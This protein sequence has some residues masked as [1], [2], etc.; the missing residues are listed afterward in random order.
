[1]ELK[2][3]QIIPGMEL[4]IQELSLGS[5]AEIRIPSD[6]AYGKNGIPRI[7]PPESELI[8][9]I[10]ILEVDGLPCDED[11]LGKLARPVDPLGLGPGDFCHPWWL[12]RVQPL[13]PPAYYLNF[14]AQTAKGRKPVLLENARSVAR[15]KS[16]ELT[17][18]DVGTADEPFI[19]TDVQRGWQ[20]NGLWD[21]K[22]F[23]DHLGDKRQ[24]LKWL[25]PVF[26]RQECLWEAPVYETSVR[27][28]IKY[29]RDLEQK[30]PNCD[31]ENAAQCPR[32]YLN[33]WPAFAQ[34]PWL[35][36]FVLPDGGRE[37]ASS[38]QG[39]IED[40]NFL[41]IR[42][43]EALRESLLEGLTARGSYQPPDKA[44]QT[45]KLEDEDWDLTKIFMSPKGAITRLHYDNGGAHA[46]SLRLTAGLVGH[47]D[48]CR[49]GFPRSKDEKQRMEQQAA[50]VRS[51][52]VGDVSTVMGSLH[53]VDAQ[54]TSLGQT[55][56]H[57]ASASGA[58]PLVVALL[59][60]GADCNRCD[61]TGASAVAL[62]AAAGHAHVLEKLLECNSIKVPTYD[63]AGLTPVHKAVGFGQPD[64]LRSLL[65]HGVDPNVPTGEVTLPADSGAAPSRHETALHIA[66]R[67]LTRAIN[68]PDGAGS[69]ERQ[70]LQQR[71]LMRMLVSYRANAL[72]KDVNGDT[73][74]HFS[75]RTGDL[76]GFCLLLDSDGEHL[77]PFEGDEGLLNGSWLDPLDPDVFEKWPDAKKATPYLA[78]VEAGE[79]I[80]APKG[81]W[82]YAV[83]LDSSVTIM[84]NFYST[85]NQWDL[86]RRKD[87]G[88]AGAIAT[89][90]L[91]SIQSASE[92]VVLRKQPKLKNQPDSVIQEIAQKTVLKLRVAPKH[93][94]A[95]WFHT[96]LAWLAAGQAALID[97][98]NVVCSVPESY[99]RES[100]KKLIQLNCDK[101]SKSV[102]DFTSLGSGETDLDRGLVMLL[103][104]DYSLD[105]LQLGTLWAKQTGET[106]RL[107]RN[108]ERTERELWTLPA[109]E[110]LAQT[111]DAATLAVNAWGSVMLQGRKC[112]TLPRAPYCIDTSWS[113]STV[114]L[115]VPMACLAILFTISVVSSWILPQPSKD[116]E[117]MTEREEVFQSRPGSRTPRVSCRSALKKELE[118]AWLERHCLR[119]L[120]GAPD[121][122]NS[123]S[124]LFGA[125]KETLDFQA[126]SV[127]NQFE[128]FLSL[129]RSSCAMV[130]D[131]SVG[132]GASVNEAILLQEAAGDLYFEML[133]GFI[134]WRDN[135]RNYEA[136]TMLSLSEDEPHCC[137]LE[138]V[139]LQRP[140]PL[141]GAKWEPLQKEGLDPS[142]ATVLSRQL[143]EM[144][145]YL[146][147]WGEAG[148]VRF[149]PEAI[150][151]ITELALAANPSDFEEIYGVAIPEPSLPGAPFRSNFF[152]SKIIRPI[153]NVVF[154]EWYQYVD[155]DQNNQKDKKKLKPGLENF[156]PPDVSWKDWNEFFCD[157]SRMVEGLLLQD[158]TRLFD[159]PHERR[160]L[161][162]PRVDWQVT[163]E[164]AETKTHREIH[165]LWG[166]FATTHRIVLLHLILFFSGVCAVAG[167]AEPLDGQQPLLG[168]S[169]GVRFAAVAL[170]VPVHALLWAC[171]R[172]QVT[173]RVLRLQAP[174]AC[175]GRSLWKALWWMLPVLT[176]A[177]IRDSAL[178]ED[179]QFGL[180]L[181][182]LLVLHFALSGTGLAYLLFVPS[183][184]CIRSCGSNSD[185]MWE[186][187][188]VPLTARLVRYLFWIVL[189]SVKFI[190]GLIIFRAM[191][192]ATVELQ[193]ALPGRESVSE[194]SRIYYSTE[195]GSDFLLWFVLWFTTL[196]LFISDT[197]L[198]FTLLCSILGVSTVLVQRGCRCFTWALEDSVAKLPERFSRK[199]L[200][201]SF[202]GSESRV[203]EQVAHFSPYFPAIWDRILEYMRYEDKIDN[204]LMGDLSF[205]S[206]ESGHQVYWKQLRQPLAKRRTRE[207][208]SPVSPP[209]TT[210]AFTEDTPGEKIKVPDIFREKTAFEVGFKTYCCMHDAHWPNNAD[211]QW[212]LL[213]LSRG[214]GLPMPRPFRAPYFPGLTVCIPH[215]GESILM[216][217]KELFQGRE[218]NV[219]LMDW[220]AA[221]Y[222][223]EFLTF[224]NRMQ[225]DKG[226]TAELDLVHPKQKRRYYS[227]LIDGACE[228]L[229]TGLKKA[230]FRVE[231]P[232]YPI[233][234][235]GKGDNQ[236]HAIPFMRGEFRSKKRG[237]SLSKRIV[238][239]PE[240]ITSDIGSI[241]DF[242]ASAEVAFGT[243]LQRTYAVLGARMHYGHPDIM[244]KLFMMQQG[245]VSKATKTV[246]LSEDIFAGMDFTLR[247]NGRTIKHSEY[248]H[249]AKGRD[250]GFNTVL[251]FFSKLSSG[252][253]EQVL[254]RQAFR[255]GQVLHLPEALTFYYAHVGY[256]FTQLFVSWSMPLLV[257]VWLLVLLADEVRDGIFEA[258]LNL[259]QVQ[260][261]S[262]EVMA[263]TVGVWFSWL[264][265]LFLIATS[266]PLLAEMWMERNLKVACERFFKQMLTLSPLMF[267]FQAKIIGH[268]VINEIRYGGATYVSTGRGLPTDRR[269]FIGE[270]VPGKF[271]LKRLGGLYL[272]YAS[273]AYYD[274]VTLLAGVILIYLAGGV[275]G[276]GVY[277]SDVWWVFICLFLTVASWLWAPFIF[278]P[279]QFV[280]KHFCEDFRCLVAFFLEDSGR[281]W[282]EWYDRTQLKPRSGGLHRSM[283]AWFVVAVFFLAAWY[284]MINM[285][286]D[287]LM[288][289]YS[290]ALSSNMLHIAALLPP[291]GA[292]FTYCLLAVFFESLVGCS[293][294]LRRRMKAPG[295]TMRL[296]T[297]AT[298]ALGGRSA[299]VSQAPVAISQA[300]Q[301]PGLPGSREMTTATEEEAGRRG[302][303]TAHGHGGCRFAT[304]TRT[305]CVEKER[306]ERN[307]SVAGFI[308]KWGLLMICIFF[309]E[310]ML[311][312]NEECTTRDRTIFV[313]AAVHISFSSTE[314][315]GIWP[316]QRLSWMYSAKGIGLRR[317]SNGG[318]TDRASTRILRLLRLFRVVR[319]GKLTR[320]AVFLRDTCETQ[321]ASIQFSL[322]IIMTGMM[323]LE[324]VLACGWFGVGYY[325]SANGRSWLQENNLKEETFYKQY[326]ASLR[327]SFSQLGIGGTNI[328]AT[329]ERE[330]TYSIAV[331]VISLVTF[332]TIVSAMTSLV[333]A[334][335]SQ[336]MEETQQFGLL[337]RFLRINNIP[338]NLSGRITRFLQYTYHQRE[339]NARDPYILDYLSKSLQAE[340][341][342][343]RYRDCLSQMNFLEQLLSGEST[344]EDQIVQ[345]LAQR[346][347]AVLDSAEDDVVFCSGFEA[348]ATYFALDG[349]LCYVRTGH[350]PCDVS[351]QWISEMCLWTEWSH[352][353][354][355]SSISF[356]KLVAINVEEFCNII[357]SAGDVQ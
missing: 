214:L 184:S 144:A 266:L 280:W 228:D 44:E 219:P 328:E 50:L 147:V 331:S 11:K 75:A 62:A 56:L 168:I 293:S 252:T 356:A 190:L 234:G 336:R 25:G 202:A 8:F 351:R 19:I 181:A 111:R 113:A 141:G 333:S 12:A 99:S 171:A 28:Y 263:K 269:P 194:L 10:H 22:W 110:S 143:A 131:R 305:V 32:L 240:H 90:A 26:T 248:F 207:P 257:F 9:E 106:L 189:F 289:A 91:A 292:S 256:Y 163:L 1:M 298:K 196:V 92:F 73:P 117:Q 151:F 325:D 212:R 233:L 225:E 67:L 241:G 345:T 156:L 100:L 71:E 342:F 77:H 104:E 249:L 296:G 286:I 318:D 206:G 330:G 209:A 311:R 201:Y 302:R 116:T 142:A 238:G 20:A 253:G 46:A 78:V 208:V 123:T 344:Q 270:A 343:A 132:V 3:G 229:P 326:T 43:S 102:E 120:P 306:K 176:Y 246:N 36:S 83:S 188:P 259:E 195:W 205:K 97:D 235:D 226:I 262:A 339:K 128:H 86:I 94:M 146:L 59:K 203:G 295:I 177:G 16:S 290:G 122:A 4:A 221:K 82:H 70:Q 332:S 282:V 29:M 220:L 162:L 291:I 45:Q 96:F 138:G 129:W 314:I 236:N 321:V 57:I 21:L 192:E 40:L 2:K 155:I 312:P 247:G 103:G 317:F 244:N 47:R 211:V 283:D 334:L 347:I 140:R 258:F 93:Q 167:D 199:V 149:M 245:G 170:V 288:L 297:M 346:A 187:S 35:R 48:K 72:A 60:A 74:L 223:E 68:S 7:V 124:S 23:E 357:R 172:W 350:C 340:L 76:W 95:L 109:N 232:G 98:V 329:N 191:Y 310:G 54:L 161:A 145:T 64:C 327:W 250:L 243:I 267:I 355:L 114:A 319:L 119:V 148:N 224:S 51:I 58:L 251:G 133:D 27:E 230:K 300:P 42:E 193:I 254:T 65:D 159:L 17:N 277:S 105:N 217:K 287:A 154:D 107:C 304:T 231:L 125:L 349:A 275:S 174:L 198:W 313:L 53:D 348:D 37:A 178:G 182:P 85:S 34:L 307:A 227:S 320:F 271:Q 216:L 15:R 278:N 309:G 218:E 299:R 84:R 284:A 101:V 242:A 210:V 89:H 14:C 294:I 323:L 79:T 152:L 237:D 222:E 5:I 127:R 166:V 158:G 49:P 265:L 180:P 139:T 61:R 179:S 200:P 335:Q 285:K 115:L 204:H 301:E 169:G 108:L 87:G 153:Y 24:L 55:A 352:V 274:G 341:E 308:L 63:V 121:F 165:S 173:G 39:C 135:L 281:H 157:P 81:W 239:F 197:Q 18:F 268:Y 134:R 316:V 264:L 337:R 6:L 164:A 353:G 322:V 324:H 66:T 41:L 255:L 52:Q 118:L 130:A 150:Y 126:D 13:A 303:L 80:V 279:Y 137:G 354:D 315:Q 272:D 260:M 33:G 186:M 213:A 88:L 31:E 276:A 215:Y 273:I 69:S 185:H 136:A 112:C 175:A 261:T 38:M 30:D 183:G 160:F 338:E